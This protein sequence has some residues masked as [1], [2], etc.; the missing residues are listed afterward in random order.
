MILPLWPVAF[1][2][3]YPQKALPTVAKYDWVAEIA[4]IL[5]RPSL[6]FCVFLDFLLGYAPARKQWRWFSTSSQPRV[7]NPFSTYPEWT[8]KGRGTSQSDIENISPHNICK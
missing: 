4:N 8:R 3:D 5:I 6:F 7:F 1:F 2:G